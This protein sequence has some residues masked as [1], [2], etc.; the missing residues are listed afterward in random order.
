M[1]SVQNSIDQ[2]LNS[3]IALK[4]LV[5]NTNG[6]PSLD[7]S[8]SN[9]I[10]GYK[11]I[12]IPTNTD[13]MLGFKI[14]DPIKTLQMNEKITFLVLQ[15]Y[16]QA[17]TSEIVAALSLGNKTSPGIK[18]S[19]NGTIIIDNKLSNN[20][21]N[22]SSKAGDVSKVVEEKYYNSN[23]L[24]WDNKKIFS[25]N[26]KYILWFN[27][28]D[29]LFYL[30]YNPVHR[31][32]FK[33]YYRLSL[34]SGE[35][36]ISGEPV[37]DSDFHK[38]ITKYCNAFIVKGKQLAD[39]NN[40][41][42]IYPEIYSD[43]FCG[44]LM[45]RVTT[46][47]NSALVSSITS[48][49]FK[50][51][52]WKE[53]VNRDVL[54]AHFE[55]QNLKPGNYHS[56]ACPFAGTSG[57]LRDF[58]QSR[59]FLSESKNQSF[60]A[61]VVRLDIYEHTSS[62]TSAQAAYNYLLN[63]DDSLPPCG[64]GTTINCNQILIANYG[65]VSGNQLTSECSSQIVETE[66][67]VP[68]AVSAANK[69][70]PVNPVTQVT[71]LASITDTTTNT[72]PTTSTTPTTKITNT[73]STP[74]A[75]TTPVGKLPNITP[76]TQQKPASPPTNPQP[77][78][79]TTQ[80]SGTRGSEGLQ[81]TINTNIQ[82]KNSI[83]KDWKPLYTY[84]IVAILVVIIGISV[85]FLISKSRVTPANTITNTSVNTNTGNVTSSTAPL[86]AISAFGRYRYR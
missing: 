1:S 36:N 48:D 61:D 72:T 4:M 69:V 57:S 38:V 52:Y 18:F 76:V 40:A 17:K 54:I 39:Q 8:K 50:N 62:F 37:G 47:L 68:G 81:P 6:L 9:N 70:P 51:K 45:D 42:L 15:K 49:Y 67:I 83:F 14:G 7:A 85:Y 74:N 22:P 31:A 29:N 79:N 46:V 65:N 25:D 12:D 32:N 73:T 13:T 20:Y 19:S 82:A 26:L 44:V 24:S 21:S 28:T 27:D 63:S 11:W 43:P 56:W 23:L 84:I 33:Q 64:T 30:L 60:I 35:I 75:A 41:R 78:Q 58:A 34:L 5:K 86:E 2:I 66:K 3:D 10:W 55:A 59:E 53:N 77:T 16:N 71:P 80:P